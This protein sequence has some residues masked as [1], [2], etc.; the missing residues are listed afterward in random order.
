MKIIITAALILTSFVGYAQEAELDPLPLTEEELAPLLDAPPVE[1]TP[2]ASETTITPAEPIADPVVEPIPEQTV[3]NDE[4]PPLVE[5]SAAPV[6]ETEVA[7]PV[8]EEIVVEKVEKKAEPKIESKAQVDDEDMPFNHRKSH[9]I[10]NFGFETTKYTLPLN[11][12]GA[13]D[14]FKKKE[15]ELHGGRL[16]FGREFYLGAGF[17]F[18]G[19]VDGYY[20]GTLFE[21]IKTADPNFPGTEVSN[22]KD[23]GSYYGVDAMAHLGWM[24][25]YKTKN[26]FL[27]DMAYL[28]M[29]FFIEAGV[30][31]GR[32]Y[33]R[34]QYNFEAASVDQ[35]DFIM[36]DDFTTNSIT[37]GFNILSTSSGFYLTLKATQVN[38]SL[39]RRR[40]REKILEGGAPGSSV[41]QFDK[42]RDD[43]ADIDPVTIFALGGGYKF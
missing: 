8:V 28:A 40:I 14:Y 11:F 33:Q 1:E 12:T 41:D 16:G 34:K 29:E 2:I 7:P 18:Q 35:Y 39:D 27:G 19:R 42:R 9:W 43:N 37:G 38:I 4:V 31:K 30:G 20:M 21:G 6:V 23:T 36:E 24:F 3:V 5:E 10:G 13:S 17:L 26:P 32:S 15:R 22:E 25:D